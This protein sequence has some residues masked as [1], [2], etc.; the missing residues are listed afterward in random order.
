M[1]DPCQNSSINSPWS[2]LA[3]VLLS[4]DEILEDAIAHM[5]FIDSGSEAADVVYLAM[6]DIKNTNDQW[7]RYYFIGIAILL[8]A[9]SPGSAEVTMLGLKISK[10]WLLPVAVVYFC[11][12]SAYYCTIQLK[13]RLFRAFFKSLLKGKLG[14]ERAPVL[15]RYPLA[16]SGGAFVAREF[17]VPGYV[18]SLREVLSLGP[19]A[20][21]LVAGSISQLLVYAA[22]GFAAYQTFE[23]GELPFYVRWGVPAA[24]VASVLLAV[25]FLRNASVR[26]RYI[27][28]K[29]ADNSRVDI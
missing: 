5:Q 15:L 13:M 21:F 18:I 8:L 23:N 1:P 22:F 29:T 12:C 7:V 24:F 25:T 9:F 14:A 17:R 20:A 16:Y 2:S 10:D 3:D 27:F 26:H 6:K 19:L 11:V 4:D 28:E